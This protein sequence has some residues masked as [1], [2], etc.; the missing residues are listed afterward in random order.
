MEPILSS[1]SA[2]KEIQ[3]FHSGSHKLSDSQGDDRG[4]DRR[5]RRRKTTTLMSVFEM[6]C[7]DSGQIR[8]FGKSWRES[9]KENLQ[10]VGLVMGRF[11]SEPPSLLQRS[12]KHL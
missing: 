3:R 10:K 12:G 1:G 4:N 8:L 9:R 5:K 7:P 6:I 2:Y 11:K